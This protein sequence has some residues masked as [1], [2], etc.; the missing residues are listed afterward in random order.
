MLIF[1]MEIMFVLCILMV[2]FFVL[3]VVDR[4]CDLFVIK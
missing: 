3:S 2:I 4:C 1:R